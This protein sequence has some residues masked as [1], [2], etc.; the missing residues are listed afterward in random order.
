MNTTPD[1]L[2]LEPFP[3]KFQRKWWILQIIQK[4]LK[5]DLTTFHHHFHC[6]MIFL[7]ECYDIVWH[8]KT[9]YRHGHEIVC[10][11]IWHIV[12]ILEH[13][14]N[15][16]IFCCLGNF[17]QDSLRHSYVMRRCTQVTSYFTIAKWLTN[18]STNSSIYI[19]PLFQKKLCNARPKEILTHKES[20]H[21]LLICS[22]SIQILQNPLLNT[23]PVS[24]GDL[25]RIF[26]RW[27]S[28]FSRSFN[29]VY[30]LQLK[31]S[32]SIFFYLTRLHKDHTPWSR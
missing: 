20:G 2:P 3:A 6:P 18:Y 14:H 19:I 25:L 9:W 30:T 5:P 23:Y 15:R 22:I 32:L 11:T 13:T 8:T 31:D 7:I 26:A 28:I 1:W 17:T 29:T 24:M 21:D 10:H 27:S 4:F 16:I 12:V